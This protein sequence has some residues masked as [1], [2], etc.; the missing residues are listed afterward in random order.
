MIIKCPHCRTLHSIDKKDAESGRE[1][2]CLRCGK[3]M[4]HEGYP[5]KKGGQLCF[6]L[7]LEKSEPT[8]AP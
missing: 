2:I 8:S 7:K 6:S 1:L 4:H 5:V 3:E